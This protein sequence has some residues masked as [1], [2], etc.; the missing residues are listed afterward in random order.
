MGGGVGAVTARGQ[1]ARDLLPADPLPTIAN[2]DLAGGIFKY[3]HRAAR[4]RLLALPLQL[5]E[6]IGVPHHPVIRDGAGLLEA[7]HGR[8]R[9]PA[10]D[11]DVEVVGRRRARSAKR[12]LCSAQYARLEKGIRR[13]R[14]GDPVAT[15]FLHEPI[16]VRAVMALDPAFGLRRARRNDA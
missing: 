9:Q 15:Q 16:L 2:L 10:R 12:R 4:R 3:L 14:V 8:Q 13:R 1:D 6:T 11:R 5:Q 7:K